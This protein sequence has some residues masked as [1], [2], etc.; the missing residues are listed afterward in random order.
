ML[1]PTVKVVPGSVPLS[2]RTYFLSTLPSR[3]EEGMMGGK[4]DNH[5][6][7]K[8]RAHY[9]TRNRTCGSDFPPLF[10]PR[11]TG[12][13]HLAP[14][15]SC[16]SLTTGKECSWSWHGD[17]CSYSPLFLLAVCWYDQVASSTSSLVPVTDT[18]CFSFQRERQSGPGRAR[19]E[20]HLVQE[21]Q[22]E[23]MAEA[24]GR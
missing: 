20:H 5:L 13:D 18:A 23:L 15:L 12:S 19:G 17:D 9:F 4:A 22:V 10:S 11:M 3:V 1:I 6:P 16:A 24:D 2:N 21:G 7:P 8:S 14:S